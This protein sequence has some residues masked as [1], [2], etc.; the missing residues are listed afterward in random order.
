MDQKFFGL[1]A[2]S[3]GGARADESICPQ[4]TPVMAYI[5]SQTDGKVYCDEQALTRGTLYS[6]LDKPF[7]GNGGCCGGK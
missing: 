2:C 4:S 7:Y 1:G 3:C 6:V 5:P